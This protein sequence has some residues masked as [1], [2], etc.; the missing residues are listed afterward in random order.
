NGN[1]VRKLKTAAKKGIKRIHWDL[2]YSGTAPV[3]FYTPDP[4]NP[5]DQLE[6]GP[7]A[8]P[9]TYRVSLS[10]FED[11]LLTELVAPQSFSVRSLNLNTLSA[12]DK[13][14]YDDFCRK[15]S[16]LRRQSGFANEQ[17]NELNNKL[18]YIKPAL[19]ETPAAPAALVQSVQKIQDRLQVL[20]IKLSGDG[21]LAKREFETPP[22]INDRIGAIESGMWNTTCAPTGTYTNSFAIAEKQ[23]KEA[24]AEI[25]SIASDIGAIE[26]QLD[27]LKAPWTPG[28]GY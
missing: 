14:A 18:K 24:Q 15:V 6:T 26:K 9:G 2:R 19:I 11:G 8:L 22:S 16:E 7:L 20:Q 1:P 10:K 17:K 27:A 4:N 12:P 23:L 25:R 13:K 3:S 21:S 5:W 28:R